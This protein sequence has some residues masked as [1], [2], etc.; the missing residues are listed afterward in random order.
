[1]HDLLLTGNED[2]RAASRRVSFEMAVVLTQKS[3]APRLRAEC[4]QGLVGGHD[5]GSIAVPVDGAS[6]VVD[7]AT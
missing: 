4:R 1:M 3:D 5:A 7:D 2:A 6:P